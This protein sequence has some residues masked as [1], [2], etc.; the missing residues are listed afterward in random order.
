MRVIPPELAP[1]YGTTY[2]AVHPLLTCFRHFRGNT[3]AEL[4]AELKRWPRCGQAVGLSMTVSEGREGFLPHNY[5]HR[6]AAGEF[7]DRIEQ[8]AAVLASHGRPVFARIG[9]ENNGRW[10]G[11]KPAAY[12]AAFRRVADILRRRAAN[13]ATVWHQVT[14]PPGEPGW[15]DWYPG[16]DVIDWFGLSLFLPSQWRADHPQIGDLLAAASAASKPVM[17]CESSPMR[18]PLSDVE[19]T[20]NE[21]FVPYFEFIRSTKQVKAFTYLNMDFL[22]F[23]EWTEWGDCRLHTSPEIL[24]RYIQ[25]LR[26]P[27]YIHAEP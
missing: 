25:E 24:R 16:D 6:V 12:V 21:W 1:V 23:P 10:N 15:R 17:I 3:F 13:V 4:G 18:H 19:R 9:F 2:V 26:R 11:Y 8:L 22:Q 20:W 5:E 14:S 7:D 27:C